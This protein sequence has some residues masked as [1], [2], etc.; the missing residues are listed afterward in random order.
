MEA[1]ELFANET[2]RWNGSII[3]IPLMKGERVVGI[4]NLVRSC[5]GEFSQP[6]IRLLAM[7]A[8]QASHCHQQ[9]PPSPGGQPAGAQ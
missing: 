4:M 9:C 3:G 2:R 5:K 1:N 6:E 7:L 8:D